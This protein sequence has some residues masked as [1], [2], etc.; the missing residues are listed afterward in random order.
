[1]KWPFR[2]PIFA[3]ISD[4]Q[5]RLHFACV[6]LLFVV[7][8]CLK[9]KWITAVNGQSFVEDICDGIPNG[10]LVIDPESCS[11]FYVCSDDVLLELVTCPEN[12]WFNPD[13]QTCDFPENF[14]C[15][16]FVTT[17]TVTSPS[18]S[19]IVTRDPNVEDGIYCPSIE[20]PHAIQFIPSLIDC[21][22]YY[23]CYYGQPHPMSCL[24][25]YYWNQ[26]RRMCDYPANA[27]CAVSLPKY[28]P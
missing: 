20:N 5:A 2:S 17:P 28:L 11:G 7:C 12:L 18:T 13:I 1:M 15:H 4:S 14:V 25:G 26:A 9:C 23:I 6:A 21:E 22:R 8:G 3:F 27:N 24:E 10:T 19:T 16:L